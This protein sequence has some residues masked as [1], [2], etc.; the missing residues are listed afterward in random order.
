VKD[1]MSKMPDREC[2][3]EEKLDKSQH[4]LLGELI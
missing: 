3:D 2:W 4:Y 1:E